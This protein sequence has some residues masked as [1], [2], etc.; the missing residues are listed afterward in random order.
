MAV[1]SRARDRIDDIAGSYRHMIT[2]CLGSLSQLVPEQPASSRIKIAV[3]IQ[4][5]LS[6]YSNE[7]EFVALPEALAR[8]LKLKASMNEANALLALAG[9]SKIRDGLGHKINWR[10]FVFIHPVFEVKETHDRR[11]LQTELLEIID[12][13]AALA[14]RGNSFAA[15]KVAKD[16]FVVMKQHKLV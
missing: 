9:S 15:G 14:Y 10:S 2:K 11:D 16:I 1:D 3:E 4:D 8:D 12:K 7:F 6:K 5:F 13:Q